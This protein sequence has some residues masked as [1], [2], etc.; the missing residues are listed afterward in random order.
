[1]R[2][3][4]IL[5]MHRP[6]NYGSYL[7]TVA[8]YEFVKKQGLLP[9]I[10]DYMYP[11]DYHLSVRKAVESKT[12]PESF[13]RKKISGLCRRLIHSNRN[14]H[15]QRMKRFY[16]KHITMTRPYKSAEELVSNP[17]EFDV[18]V[19]GSDQIWNPKFI[20]NDTSFLLSWTKEEK[21]RI[22]Y[23]SSFA[24]K[25]IPQEYKE[26]FAKN[27]KRYDKIGIREQSDI[28]PCLTGQESNVVLDPTFLFDKDEWGRMVKIPSLVN[29]KYILCYFL[30]YNFSP[31]PY[32][33]DLIRYVQRKTGYK[34]VMI[35]ADPINILKGYKLFNEIG[36]EEFISLF[37]NA[38]YVITSSF[39]GTAF[40]VNFEKPFITVVDDNKSNKDN[41]QI[42]LIREL[43]VSLERVA[44]KGK[45]VDVIKLDEN[46][47]WHE[48]LEIKRAYSI[49]YFKQALA[50]E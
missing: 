16:E 30:S 39:H 47:E 37:Q 2:T 36:P 49:E 25:E 43:G 33:Y 18:Y 50:H 17:P 44:W 46:I 31:Y 10:I 29:G 27:L 4:G 41:R 40:S 6:D 20:G 8:T 23:A 24:I 28:L 1:M 15:L 42:S 32:A 3:A 35:D 12:V 38:S 7:Q 22:A 11:T 13:F 5:T 21:K 26:S 19:S 9:T 34:V 45:N 48:E 14:V